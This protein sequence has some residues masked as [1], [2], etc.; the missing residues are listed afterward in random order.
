MTT[1]PKPLRHF[2]VLLIVEPGKPD[3]FRALC[4]YESTNKKEFTPADKPSL[5]SVTC[6]DCIA[7][8]GR[9]AEPVIQWRLK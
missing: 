7:R 9:I 3:T 6:P 4:D 5:S 1:K 8:V 2:P